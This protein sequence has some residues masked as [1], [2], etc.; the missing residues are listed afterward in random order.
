MGKPYAQISNDVESQDDGSRCLLHV[1]GDN[2]L[3]DSLHGLKSSALPIQA[4]TD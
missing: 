1:R 2:V 3:T 4:A